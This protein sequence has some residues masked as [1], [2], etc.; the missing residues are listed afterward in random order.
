MYIK[1][2]PFILALTAAA[3]SLGL[4]MHH[5]LGSQTAIGLALEAGVVL[6]AWPHLWL[7]VLPA[8]LPAIGLAPWTGWITFLFM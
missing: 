7:L 8:L 3:L 2:L 5:P 4:A 1:P 6:C